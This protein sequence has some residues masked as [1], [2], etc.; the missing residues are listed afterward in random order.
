METRQ[1]GPRG[2]WEAAGWT[3]V[4]ALLCLCLGAGPAPAPAPAH[5]VA[6]E[7]QAW[8]TPP[9]GNWTSLPPAG[10]LPRALPIGSQLRTGPHS[11]LEVD[12]GPERGWLRLEQDSELVLRG[13]AADS[14]AGSLYLE[15]GGLRAR[16]GAQAPL[17]KAPAGTAAAPGAEID[18]T[19]E[20]SSGRA[21][22]KVEKGAARLAAGGVE[23]QVVAGQS[24]VID[25]GQSP[26]RT[27]GS[28]P[29]PPVSAAKP[30]A[31][32]E[33]APAPASSAPAP[34]AS[35]AAPRAGNAPSPPP[36]A[37]ASAPPS[38]A[39]PTPM[40][41]DI[42][43]PTAGAAPATAP[44]PPEDKGP[45]WQVREGAG[46]VS[47]RVTLGGGALPQVRVSEGPVVE[48]EA[49]GV[50]PQPGQLGPGQPGE[51]LLRGWSA[52]AGPEGGLR[53][54]VELAAG[55]YTLLQH[56]DAA[57][58][59]YALDLFARGEAKP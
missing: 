17:L 20:R 11:S 10:G 4:L 45:P 9:G 58:G 31:T 18:W 34:P 8:H 27:E 2:G 28:P 24:G 48:V 6:L 36:P 3:L 40:S 39:Q 25:F 41:A 52:Q 21:T 53:L 30:E 57:N 50:N 19:S 37:Q 51:K 56:F 22:L 14:P 49:P 55:R 23:I 15:A 12:L 42:A 1:S 29:A 43:V 59:Q 7:G 16:L 13:P 38:P 35:A 47:L 33:P 32:P 46:V 5:L 44:A 54:R 26:G